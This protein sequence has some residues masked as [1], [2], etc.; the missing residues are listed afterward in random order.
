MK[1]K[2]LVAAMLM[3]G[4]RANPDKGNLVVP[5]VIKS[6]EDLIVACGENPESE[7]IGSPIDVRTDR[8]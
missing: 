4:S 8:Y 6:A 1:N 3:A 7:I 5:L 2:T